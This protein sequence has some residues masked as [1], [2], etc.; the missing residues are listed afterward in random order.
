MDYK[1]NPKLKRFGQI[2]LAVFIILVV[3]ETVKGHA[4]D[5]AIGYALCWSAIATGIVALSRWYYQ[6][7]GVHCAICDPQ[8]PVTKADSEKP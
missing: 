4:F 2:F 1:I 6:S 3:T 7:R 8:E 5:A